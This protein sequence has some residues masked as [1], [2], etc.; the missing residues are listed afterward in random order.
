MSKCAHWGSDFKGNEVL[1]GDSFLLD[2]ANDEVVQVSDVIEY[3]TKH[4]G[5]QLIKAD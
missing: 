2:P 3:L 5:F 4:R 1:E